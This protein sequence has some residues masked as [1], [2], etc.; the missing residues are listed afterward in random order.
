MTNVF[1]NRTFEKWKNSVDKAK[2]FGALLTDLSRAFN[3]LG[4]ELLT[5]KLNA[6]G[7]TLLELRLIHEY[8]SNRKQRGK[9]D[10]NYSSCS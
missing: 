9:I 6:Y 3:C 10:D 4:H 1:T 8:L 2:S 7:F 5:T